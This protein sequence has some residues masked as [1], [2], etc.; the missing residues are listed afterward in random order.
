MFAEVFR[1]LSIRYFSLGEC[2]IDYGIQVNGTAASPAAARWG[3]AW[4]KAPTAAWAAWGKALTRQ[5]CLIEADK[6]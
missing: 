3:A 4:G 6:Q 5:R 1:E 2:P